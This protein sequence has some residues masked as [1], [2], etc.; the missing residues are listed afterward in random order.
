LLPLAY[1]LIDEYKLVVVEF[2]SNKQLQTLH[3]VLCSAVLVDSR[4]FWDALWE[5]QI[6]THQCKTL[7]LMLSKGCGVSIAWE[8][9]AG[10]CHFLCPSPGH[11]PESWQELCS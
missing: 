7:E 5:T 8:K 11:L 2:T 9:S 10:L 6:F 1:S 3:L 4:Q